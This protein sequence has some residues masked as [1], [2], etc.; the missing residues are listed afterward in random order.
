MFSKRR[1][2][3]L[4]GTAVVA[5]TV[6]GFVFRKHAVAPGWAIET[7]VRPA[8]VSAGATPLATAAA[9]PRPRVPDVH[10]PP[11]PVPAGTAPSGQPAVTAF[12]DSKEYARIIADTDAF[13]AFANRANLSPDAQAGVSHVVA[14]Y[15]M[16]DASLQGSTQDPKQLAS[17]RRQL[18]EH[19]HIR[20]RAKI[21][22]SWEAFEAS[23]LLPPLDAAGSGHT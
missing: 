4:V 12:R 1:V 6:A 15:Y 5:A 10:T 9:L 13:K 7:P 8:Q 11:L 22:E 21:P 19:M 3:F 17:M 20:V 2:L 16:D 18:L 23:G 14:L